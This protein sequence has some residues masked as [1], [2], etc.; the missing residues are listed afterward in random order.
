[1][2]D[3]HESLEG[4]LSLRELIIASPDT[5]LKD[6]MHTKIVKITAYD[7]HE[8]VAE[9]FH[10]YGLLAVPVVNDQNEIL[11]IVTVDDVLEL[12]MP[13]RS[14]G[15]IYSSLFVRRHQSKGGQSE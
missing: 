5:Q 3:E 13:E 8:K 10:K 15:E 14:R 7:D 1:V 6:I 2:V 12:L 9:V 11:G 4:V